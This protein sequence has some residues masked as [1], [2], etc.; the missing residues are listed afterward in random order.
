M[1]SSRSMWRQVSEL[2]SFPIVETC[3]FV[4][5]NRQLPS[6]GVNP[7]VVALILYVVHL[8]DRLCR[9][10]HVAQKHSIAGEISSTDLRYI[11]RQRDELDFH[12]AAL[13]IGDTIFRFGLTECV[14][15]APGTCRQV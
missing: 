9:S 10:R 15:I 5:S 7:V 13:L 6:N 8:I 14:S 11:L 2:C 3:S 1:A 4:Y 12:V